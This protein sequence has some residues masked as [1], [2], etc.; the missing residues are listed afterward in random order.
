MN[1]WH[2]FD[3]VERSP[4]LFRP[5]GMPVSWAEQPMQ[6]C[7]G[8][9]GALGPAA[10]P[11]DRRDRSVQTL[12]RYRERIEKEELPLRPGRAA[13]G[14]VVGQG[15]QAGPMPGETSPPALQSF[16]HAGLPRQFLP[17]GRGG[18]GAA[19]PDRGV[20][21]HR[22]HTVASV[23]LGGERQRRQHGPTGDRIGEAATAGPVGRNARRGEVLFEQADVR[24][25]R[26]GEDSDAVGAHPAARIDGNEDLSD[27]V[28][29][30]VVGI[31]DAD[32]LGR[33]CDGELGP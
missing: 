1:A 32:D 21:E 6:Q 9:L 12:D 28:A 13:P 17:G 19:R 4:F 3:L 14:G 23:S 24:V 20:A 22:Q 15:G 30:L 16:D 25:R 10:P 18:R 5:R 33:R 8:G 2:L 27:H 7:S 29:N 26:R 11:R 31:G